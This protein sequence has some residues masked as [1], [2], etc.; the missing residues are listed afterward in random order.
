MKNYIPAI[1][2]CLAAFAASADTTLWYNGDFNNV[3]S[4]RDNYSSY[5]ATDATVYDDFTVST[6]SGGWHITEVFGHIQFGDITDV[7]NANWSIRSGVSAG[8]G[9]T[10]VASGANAPITL[11][12]TGTIFYGNTEYKV[13][14]AGLDISLAPGTYWL[15]VQP[16][17]VGAAYMSTTS[18]ANGA[19]APLDD[20]NAFFNSPSQGSNFELQPAPPSGF[21]DYSMGIVGTKVANPSPI[22]LNVQLAGT[23]LVLV[24]AD[25]GSVFSLQAAPAITG[26]FTNVPGAISPY[27]N[28]IAGSQIYFRLKSN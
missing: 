6:A 20:G 8:N 26:T 10:I 1:L 15:G 9:G 4:L 21:S 12:P 18:G 19:G 5:T 25:S 14:I 27:T 13:D 23:K 24:W 22:P 28:T 16:N 17:T 11:T 3:S 2:L 7:T